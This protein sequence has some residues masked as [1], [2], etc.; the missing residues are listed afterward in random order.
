MHDIVGGRR[1]DECY[2]QRRMRRRIKKRWI[3]MRRREKERGVVRY[4]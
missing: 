1:M 2:P 4:T 3:A